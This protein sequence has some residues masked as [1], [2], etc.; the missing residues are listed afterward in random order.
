M[1]WEVGEGADM[2]AQA[3]SDREKGEGAAA[4]VPPE[5]GRPRKETG[6]GGEEERGEQADGESW[7]GGPE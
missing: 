7:A 5:L 3:I 6:G 2:Q 1:M 4:A